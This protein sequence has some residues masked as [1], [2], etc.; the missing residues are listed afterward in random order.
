MN[1]CLADYAEGIFVYNLVAANGLRSRS[2]ALGQAWILLGS[3]ENAEA[4]KMPENAATPTR[5]LHAVLARL[6]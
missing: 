4:R 1:V 6:M 3:R 5:P 2:M